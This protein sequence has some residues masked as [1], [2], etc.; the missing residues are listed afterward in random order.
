VGC[1]PTADL[2]ST[3]RALV[4][5]AARRYDDAT[6]VLARVLPRVT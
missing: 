1:S 3:A 4:Q 2:E 5:T 6:I